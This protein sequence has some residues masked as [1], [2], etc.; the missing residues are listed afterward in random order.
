MKGWYPIAWSDELPGRTV[1]PKRLGG[2]DLVVWRG[3]GQPYALDAYCDHLGAHL[4]YNGTV[5]GE[6]VRC[7]F[8]AWTWSP[9]GLNTDI[10][11][12]DRTHKGRRIRRWVTAERAGFVLA[13][14]PAGD[15]ATDDPE[16]PAPDLAH[17]DDADP[18]LT[19]TEHVVV[20]LRVL[21]ENLVDPHAVRALLGEAETPAPEVLDDRPGLFRVKHRFP[22]GDLDVALHGAGL[23]VISGGFGAVLL[24]FTPTG[25]GLDLRLAA[26]AGTDV[27]AVI[28][29]LRLAEAMSFTSNPALPEPE[30][31]LIARFRHWLAAAE[32]RVLAAVG[33]DRQEVSG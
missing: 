6:D 15:G 23:A 14:K 31:D 32:T 8:H 26:T 21:L 13:W 29:W 9:E 24:G 18:D 22:H 27:P 12:S 28:G 25:T 19:T 16:M 20:D 1:L 4:G 17:W 11:Y 2:Q 30:C 7:F 33:H 10:P 3:G 5:V